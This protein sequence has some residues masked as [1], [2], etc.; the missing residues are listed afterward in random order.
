MRYLF[1]NFDFLI[2]GAFTSLS[3]SF[4]LPYYFYLATRTKLRSLKVFY[5]LRWSS[6]KRKVTR[7]GSGRDSNRLSMQLS[8]ATLSERAANQKYT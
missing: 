7:L 1:H 2:A 5:L 8:L 6:R 4:S 3:P